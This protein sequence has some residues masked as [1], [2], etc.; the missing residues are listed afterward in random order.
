MDRTV[1]P[2]MTTMQAFTS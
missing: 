2:A 1:L